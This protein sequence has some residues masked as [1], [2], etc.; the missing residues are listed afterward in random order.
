VYLQV[1][2][3]QPVTLLQVFDQP[4]METNCTRRGA[5]TVSSQALTLLNSDFMIRQATAFAER[6]RKASPADPVGAA[7]LQA[8]ARPATLGERSRLTAFLD[9]QAAH[10][11]Q[12]TAARHQALTDLCQMLLSANEFVYVD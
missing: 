4:V 12:D 7:V 8:F 11:G 6:V 5:S 2:R 1:R 3:S 9:A 10:Y